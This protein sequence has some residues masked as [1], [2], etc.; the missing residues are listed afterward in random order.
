MP[1]LGREF[2]LDADHKFKSKYL[3][4]LLFGA[5]F[6]VGWTPCV[7]PVLGSVLGLAASQPGSAF[8]LLLA[9]SI[10]LGIPFLLVGLFASQATVLIRKYVKTLRYVYILF[11][12]LLII[13]GI[14]IFTQTL[15]AIANFDLLNKILLK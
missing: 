1:F 11:G 4:S 9:Y 5:A 13:L 8:S 7:G 2:K 10:G 3:T 6:A 12:I 14:L 15:S